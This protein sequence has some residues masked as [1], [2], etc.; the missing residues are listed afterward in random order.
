MPSV[1]VPIIDQLVHPS[2]G[3]LTHTLVPGGPFSGSGTLTPPQNPLVALTYGLQWSF[4]TVPAG[5]GRTIGNPDTFEFPIVQVASVY[6]LL[7]GHQITQQVEFGQW[8]GGCYFWL[9]PLPSAILYHVAPSCVVI[10][11]W[12]QT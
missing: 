9:E 5:I 7:D 2:Y 11:N 1:T 6:T 3:L 8:D 10:F 12:L 4:F